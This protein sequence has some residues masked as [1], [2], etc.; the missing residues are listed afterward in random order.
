MAAA[1][2]EATDEGRIVFESYG[3]GFLESLNELPLRK[4]RPFH[5]HHFSRARDS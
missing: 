3:Y 2:Y 5:A 1:D 4:L